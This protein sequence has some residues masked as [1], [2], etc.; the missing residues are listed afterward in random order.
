MDLS[1]THEEVIQLY[2]YL[3]TR[4]AELDIQV[5]KIL[6][7]LEDYLYDKLTIEEIEKIERSEKIK[8]KLQEG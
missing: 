3:K 1:I 5:L 4:E 6:T 7:K 2:R 8:I